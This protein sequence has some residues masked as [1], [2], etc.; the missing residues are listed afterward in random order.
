M[1]NFDVSAKSRGVVLFANNTE[2]VDYESIARRSRQL[3]EHYLQLPVTIL[4]SESTKKNARYSIDSGQFEQ[5]NN[6]KRYMAYELSPYD[7]TLLL[8]SD[9][10]VLDRSLLTV[11]DTLED[12]KI[13]RH[14]RYL[15][16]T[17]DYTMGRYS[18]PYLWAT[19]VA[20]E[21]SSRAEML[22][23][24]VGRV[25]RNYAYYRQLY[26]ITAT[27]FRNDY[28]F[29]IAD[30]VLNGYTQ[31]TRNY[32]PWTMLSVGNTIDSMTL[33]NN[34][35]T[36][37]SQGRAWVLPRQSLHVMSK[38]WLQSEQFEQFIKDAVGA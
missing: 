29:T 26:N 2:T 35:I 11:L 36:V 20:F 10:L 1:K 13:V 19:V 25:E 12:Y 5:W 23:D 22:F 6:Q 33:Q 34:Q 14:N 7:Q 3:I 4:T 37:K 32:I 17:V 21:R 16:D 24:F 30:L 38:A 8:D 9:Y 31:D 18:I 28:A 15:D 27:N